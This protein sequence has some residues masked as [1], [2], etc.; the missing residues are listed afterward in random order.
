M[1]RDAAEDLFDLSLPRDPL[2]DL[3]GGVF[4]LL[5]FSARAL[6]TLRRRGREHRLVDGRWKWVR[7]P[8][9]QAPERR[10]RLLALR[11]RGK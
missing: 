4:T 3:T 7:V 5:P 6:E 2:I 8:S 1:L 9:A 11:G 10:G